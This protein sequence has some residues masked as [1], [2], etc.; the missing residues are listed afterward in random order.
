MALSTKACQTRLRRHAGYGNSQV[1]VV[2]NNDNTMPE[3]TFKLLEYSCITKYVNYSD[4]SVRAM[5]LYTNIGLHT[6]V[7]LRH[8]TV[9]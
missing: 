2:G 9:G 3:K 4:L 7:Y 6:I 1:P 5:G 8:P